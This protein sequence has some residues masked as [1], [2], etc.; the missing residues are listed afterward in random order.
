MA[1]GSHSSPE[2]DSP[3]LRTCRNRR[4]RREPTRACR[5]FQ[6]RKRHWQTEVVANSLETLS[7]RG[8]KEYANEAQ[9]VA[10]EATIPVN[11]ASDEALEAVVAM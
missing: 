5:C 6:W 9:A 3:I 10:D 7:G 11:G 4:G 2:P 1:S 8:K